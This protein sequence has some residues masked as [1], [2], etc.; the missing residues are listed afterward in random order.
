MPLTQEKY[1]KN[2]S[3]SEAYGRRDGTRRTVFVE[4]HGAVLG[5]LSDEHAHRYG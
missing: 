2:F 4:T 1:A 3:R 5:V